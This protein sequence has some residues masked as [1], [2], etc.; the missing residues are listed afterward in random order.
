MC[1][2]PPRA[3]LDDMNAM[4]LVQL[5]FVVIGIPAILAAATLELW[6]N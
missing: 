3:K 6:R 1:A 4:D 2:G 5:L